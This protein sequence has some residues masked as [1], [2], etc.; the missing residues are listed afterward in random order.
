METYVGNSWQETHG[1][2]AEHLAALP[3][4]NEKE[5]Q[6]KTEAVRDGA[7]E[8]TRVKVMNNR[9]LFHCCLSFS[10]ETLRVKI[11]AIAS[12]DLNRG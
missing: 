5:E 9:T 1:T 4:G 7:N 8:Q 11:V 6:G 2:S 3:T 12:C 10:G